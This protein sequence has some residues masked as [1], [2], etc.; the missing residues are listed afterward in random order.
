MIYVYIVVHYVP[1]SI[2]FVSLV[3]EKEIFYEFLQYM[4]MAVILI[5]T[6]IIYVHIGS[7][8]R[9]LFNIKFGYDWLSGLREKNL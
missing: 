2:E 9:F 4:G 1:S 3:S 7:S 6:W 8:S 5:M